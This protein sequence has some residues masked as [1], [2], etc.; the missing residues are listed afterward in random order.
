VDHCNCP[1]ACKLHGK[2]VECV[3]VHRGEDDDF[4]RSRDT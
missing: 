1:A 2:C 4:E 3:I